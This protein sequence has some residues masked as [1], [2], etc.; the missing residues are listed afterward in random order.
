MRNHTSRR[1]AAR[2]LALV[3]LL[4]LAGCSSEPPPLYQ[5]QYGDSPPAAVTAYVFAPHPLF[6]PQKMAEV[7]GAIVDHVNAALA[8][9]RIR[10]KLE[11]SRSYAA[12]NEKLRKRQVHFALPNPYQTVLSLDCGYAVFGKMADDEAFCGVILVR[13]DNP[14]DSLQ[15]LRG[16]T[17][18]F[19]APTALAATMLPELFLKE[20]GV[21]P[22]RDIHQVFVG[23]H[24][25]VLMNVCIGASAAGCTWPAAWES[26]RKDRPDMARRIEIRWRTGSL[27]SNGLVARDDVPA[28][29]RDKVAE[30]LFRLKDS[31]EGR[32]LLQAAAATAFVP[33]DAGAYAP[34]HAFIKRYERAVRPLKGLNE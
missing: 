18:S 17:V 32:R 31:P 13:K 7:Y 22:R 28:S 9:E 24:D 29:V 30:T 16:G 20:N 25:S 2:A 1:S 5:P 12:F 15:G 23:T 21:D 19:P 33:A 6:N 14:V 11:A 8:G 27:P 26:F 3:L 34:V 10:L 4:G